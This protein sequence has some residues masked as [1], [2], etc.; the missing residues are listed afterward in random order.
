MKKKE[1]LAIVPARSGSKGIKN[2]NSAC[3]NGKPLIYYTI[4]EARKSALIDRLVVSTDSK[5]I[6]ML[7]QSFGAEVPFM[8]PKYLA[9]DKTKSI[10]VVLDVLDTLKKDENYKPDL[11][12]LLQPTSPL[13]KRF[14]IDEALQRLLKSNADSIVSLCQLR[15]PHPRKIKVIKKGYVHPFLK[16]ADSSVPRQLLSNCYRLNGA[17]YAAYT[18]SVIKKRRFLGRK[19][20]PYIMDEKYSVNIDSPLDLM[21]AD[22]LLQKR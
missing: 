15:E 9:S 8:R 3:L 12:V 10:D 20:I 11:I 4:D 2:K 1:I 5:R 7:A 16:G 13:R 22:A 19:V 14:H 6:A 18:D 17:I 21:L